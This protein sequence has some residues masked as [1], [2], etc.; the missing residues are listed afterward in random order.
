MRPTEF[1]AWVLRAGMTGFTAGCKLLLP[2]VPR[3]GDLVRAPV[4][5]ELSIFG[6]IYEVTMQDDLAVRQLILVGDLEPEVVADQQENRLV[7]IELGVLTIGFRQGHQLRHGLPPQPPVSLDSL[8]VCDE[9][10]LC[11]F[12]ARLDYLPLVLSAG[13]APADELLAVHLCRAVAAR[14]PAERHRFLVTAGRELARRLSSDL[15]RLETILERL[16]LAAHGE[17]GH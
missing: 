17:S 8:Q 2:E 7:P 4:Q 11:A 9:A 6:L 1:T 3:F 12:T 13:Q 15:L 10:Q 5:A 16:R 14:P